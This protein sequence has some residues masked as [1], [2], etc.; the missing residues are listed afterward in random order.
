[1]SWLMFIM[2]Q[3]L[4]LLQITLCILWLISI[5]Y[6]SCTFPHSSLFKTV[7]ICKAATEQKCK[8]ALQLTQKATL[9]KGFI[10]PPHSWPLLTNQNPKH[11][12]PITFSNSNFIN[13]AV[14][15]KK[16][17]NKPN[18]LRAIWSKKYRPYNGN[19]HHFQAINLKS[20]WIL[21]TWE[22]IWLCG[23]VFVLGLL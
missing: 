21:S 14:L 6:F 23:H 9:T 3:T 10:P 19:S 22:T 2:K 15:V 13:I 17:K 11:L 16:Q 4:S 12:S 8:S 18:V 7:A 1:M 5:F 20:T